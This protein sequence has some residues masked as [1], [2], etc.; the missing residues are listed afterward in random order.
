MATSLDIWAVGIS[1]VIGGQYFS[2]NGGLEAG[3]LSY[4]IAIALVGL[5][6]LCLA[7]SMAEMTSM[8]PFA[9]GAYGLGRCTLG[10]FMG[11][12]LGICEILEYIAYVSCSVVVLGQMLVAEWPA[13]A[14]V[15][16]LLWFVIYVI[17]GLALSCERFFWLWNRLLALV[18]LGLVLSFCIG[19][20]TYIDLHQH[21]QVDFN[22]LGGPAAYL[23]AFPQAAW[24]F[25]GIESLNTLTS[26]TIN[27]KT[28][29]PRGQV[30]CMVTLLVTSIWVYVVAIFLPPG[31]PSLATELA[32]LNRGFTRIFN[33]SDSAATMLAVPATFATAQG[34]MLAYSHIIMAMAG[35]K[36]LPTPCA[37]R[38]PTLH[39]P[40][41]ALLA[42]SVLSFALCFVVSTW[43]LG[44]L[45]F[46]VGMFFGYMSY[47]AQCLGYIFLK[48]RH[49]S[50]TREFTSPVG[51]PGAIFAITVWLINLFSIIGFQGDL[52]VAFGVAMSIILLCSI[53]YHRFVKFRQSFSD[54]EQ[55]LMLF[56]HI[57]KVVLAT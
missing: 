7:F 26:S 56:V 22:T 49:K 24:F 32:P 48:R 29:I 36:L 15:Q 53:Y 19:S 5:A 8:M 34:F 55:K 28:T 40:L 27:P 31:M 3:T 39:T 51:V 42:G 35:S 1:I 46:N 54:E 12:L 30:A 11:F 44:T 6:Y 17:A 14:K 52:H 10:F 50:M 38:H 57:G 20:M 43:S 18:S 9:G 25:V 16:P 41:H 2:W 37:A 33:I 47:T 4:G 13:L 23:K 21:G 45:V